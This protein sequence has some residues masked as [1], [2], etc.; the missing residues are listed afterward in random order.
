MYMWLFAILFL[1]IIV[2]YMSNTHKIRK[3]YY[4]YDSEIDGMF[5]ERVRDI[6]NVSNWKQYYDI[7]EVGQ[8]P[9]DITIELMKRSDLNFTD[10]RVYPDGRPIYYSATTVNT[11]GGIIKIDDNNWLY[12]VKESGLDIDSYREYVI[13]H[14]FG[15][16]LGYDHIRCKDG[17]CPVMYQA[18]T[19]C[20]DNTCLT[21]PYKIDM[22]NRINMAEGKDITL[23]L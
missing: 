9:A 1:L 4:I 16:G 2:L 21:Q 22:S 23:N 5:K 3:T 18:T 10:G 6:L 17:F 14:E 12:G 15:H 20:Y 7:K 11:N 13:N 8:L 19:G